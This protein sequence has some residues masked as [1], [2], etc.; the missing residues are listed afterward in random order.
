MNIE[1]SV[2]ITS[3]S[4]DEVRITIRDKASR[5][6][7]VRVTM[8]PHD[9]AMALTGLSEVKAPA[10]TGRLDVVGM[11][12]IG[13]SRSVIF[14]GS[15]LAPTEDMQRWLL[16]NCQES[17]WEIDP[18]LGYQRSKVHTPEGLRLNYRVFKYEL[19]NVDITGPSGSSA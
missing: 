11:T 13:E 7:V 1:T 12:K 2:T 8:T 15:S 17:G 16:E 5:Q 9:L 18:Y 19:P 14:P 6:M 10:E 3:N 4:E